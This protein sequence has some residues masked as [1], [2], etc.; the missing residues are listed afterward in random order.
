[1]GD[2]EDLADVRREMAELEGGAG[3]FGGDVEADDG[4]EAHRVHVVEVAKVEG[5]VFGGGQELFDGQE[6]L[7]ADA[8]DEAA[9]AEDGGGG[10]GL[11]DG[12]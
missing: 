11:V 3:G 4:A 7:I 8:G 2:A 6:E 5:D 9:A 1:M 12:E 10:A